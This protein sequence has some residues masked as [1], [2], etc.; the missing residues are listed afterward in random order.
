MTG[1]SRKVLSADKKMEERIPKSIEKIQLE[2]K[3]TV[4]SLK[5][6]EVV[7]ASSKGGDIRVMCRCHNKA[8]WLNILFRFLDRERGRDWYSFIGQKYMVWDGRLTAAWVL[9]FEAEDLDKAV[10]DIRKMLL[11]IHA[12]VGE[13]TPAR[14]T[15]QLPKTSYTVALPS[16]SGFEK[17][18]QERTGPAGTRGTGS[19]A[20]RTVSINGRR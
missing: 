16:N 6:L 18:L 11:A 12:E 19:D 5:C 1:K 4:D 7:Q 17:T 14:N 3:Q 8:A 15:R 10:Q 20:V 13:T 9:I 2:L